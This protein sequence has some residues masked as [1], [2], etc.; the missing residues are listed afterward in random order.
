VAS[1]RYS[2][3][4]GSSACQSEGCEALSTSDIVGGFFAG[5]FAVGTDVQAARSRG[6]DRSRGKPLANRISF[7]AL[8]SSDQKP[9][10]S[11]RADIG[12]FLGVQLGREHAE[13]H[14][15]IELLA[16][17]CDRKRH[18]LAHIRAQHLLES[19]TIAHR[20]AVEFDDEIAAA[21]IRFR[22]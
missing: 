20:G 3:F 17:A 4:S 22:R 11:C 21:Q 6:A 1:S 10:R 5:S 7:L 18:A 13:A 15:T 19:R 9:R 2:V 16:V 14:E 8:A 12:L